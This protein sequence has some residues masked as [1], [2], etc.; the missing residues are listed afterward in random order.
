MVYVYEDEGSDTLYPLVDL[1]PVFDLRC[2]RFTLLEKL[3]R[4]Y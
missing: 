4:R 2:G 1:R 3:R